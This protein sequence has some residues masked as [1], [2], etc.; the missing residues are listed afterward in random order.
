MVVV[1]EPT[2]VLFVVIT[3]VVVK[4]GDAK[5]S[6]IVLARALAWPA[7]YASE[8][9]RLAGILGAWAAAAIVSVLLSNLED[10]TLNV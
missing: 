8:A 7:E 2:V 5:L 1:F 10:D 9:L 4:K 3:V 6:V